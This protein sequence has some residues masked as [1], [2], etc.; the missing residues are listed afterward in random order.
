M[1]P[2]IFIFYILSKFRSDYN[3]LI[4]VRNYKWIN[5]NKFWSRL[6]SSLNIGCILQL[7]IFFSLFK[8]IFFPPLLLFV[9]FIS[10]LLVKIA[11]HRFFALAE[12]NSFKE[13]FFLWRSSISN[14]SQNIFFYGREVIRKLWIKFLECI[15]IYISSV[16]REVITS[17]SKICSTSF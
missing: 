7:S 15:F 12:K 13:G 4:Y 16:I 8:P 2:D 9:L 6:E 5:I 3:K 10:L 17:A 1:L 11:M 14:F